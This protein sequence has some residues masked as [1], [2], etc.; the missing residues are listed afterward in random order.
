MATNLINGIHIWTPQICSIYLS[1][2]AYVQDCYYYV[3]KLLD[4]DF[5]PGSGTN[6]QQRNADTP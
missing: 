4:I 5:F 3:F 2:Y 1:K 6:V